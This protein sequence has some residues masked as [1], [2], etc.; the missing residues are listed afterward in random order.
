LKQLRAFSNFL[1]TSLKRLGFTSETALHRYQK[2]QGLPEGSCDSATLRRVWAQLLLSGEDP[3]SL[4]PQVGVR[5]PEERR[6]IDTFGEINGSECDETGKRIAVG[7]SRSVSTVP[8]AGGRI[9]K[10]Q[11]LVAGSAKIGAEQ[12]RTPGECAAVVE[13]RIGAV[14]NFAAEVQGGVIRSA[15]RVEASIRIVDAVA[16]V[17][18]ELEEKLWAIKQAMSREEGRTNVL[19][20]VLIALVM[21]IAWRWMG[22][23][24]L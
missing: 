16:V 17:N 19:V 22:K 4:L 8:A 23:R 6:E 10:V 15:G 5:V 14:A 21:V 7:L 2:A 12:C 9:A 18:G 3:I 24:S 1:T 20:M 13:Q 11:K